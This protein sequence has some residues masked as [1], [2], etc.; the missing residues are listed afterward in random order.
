MEDGAGMC[1]GGP[2]ATAMLY[3]AACPLQG[4]QWGAGNHEDLTMC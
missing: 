4:P 1:P 3:G 2:V